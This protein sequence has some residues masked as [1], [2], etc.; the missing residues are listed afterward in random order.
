MSALDVF[1]GAANAALAVSDAPSAATAVN[2]EL[3]APILVSVIAN[4]LMLAYLIGGLRTKIDNL[5]GRMDKIETEAARNQDMEHR[6]EGRVHEL[7]LTMARIEERIS[8]MM[9]RVD[10]LCSEIAECPLGGHRPQ[11]RKRK[12][13]LA[14]ADLS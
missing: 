2:W 7:A 6:L 4:A 9:E 11:K 1:S 3:I 13:D 10:K 12:P 8:N 5:S 14:E